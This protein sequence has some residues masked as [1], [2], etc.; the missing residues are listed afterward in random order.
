MIWSSAR[1]SC[2][3]EHGVTSAGRASVRSERGMCEELRGM[4]ALGALQYARVQTASMH[5]AVNEATQGRTGMLLDEGCL[6]DWGMSHSEGDDW[7]LIHRYAR[8]RS[9]M[10]ATP[11]PSVIRDHPLL[12]HF[13]AFAL[14]VIHTHHPALH[15]RPTSRPH[16]RLRALKIDWWQG[17]AKT[18]GQGLSQTPLG[19]QRSR[20]Q[21]VSA[22][23]HFNLP[24]SLPNLVSHPQPVTSARSPPVETA[25]DT[26][27]SHL[28]YLKPSLADFSFALRLNHCCSILAGPS[29]RFPLAFPELLLPRRVTDV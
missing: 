1:R 10:P 28:T 26:F 4:G 19:Q 2:H 6:R 9:D 29:P 16:A 12:V 5:D 27:H 23:R 25:R 8:A 18:N 7:R 22:L 24:L 3:L 13:G 20:A 17:S 11:A 21:S 14:G 15:G